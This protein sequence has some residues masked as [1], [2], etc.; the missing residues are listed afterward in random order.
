MKVYTQDDFI[1]AIIARAFCDELTPENELN[2]ATLGFFAFVKH[3]RTDEEKLSLVTAGAD[4]GWNSWEGSFRFISRAEVGLDNPRGDPSMTYP[5]AE[6][7]QLD[8]L[9]QNQSAATGVHVYRSNQIPQLAN[10]VLFGDNPSGEVF[11]IPADDLMSGG[12]DGIRRIL[13]NDG[14]EAKTLLELIRGKNSEQGRDQARRADLRFG[15]GPD[16][17]VFLLNKR[18]GIVRLLVR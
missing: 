15:S 12:Q 16:G 17:Q 2:D 14:G 13:F 10:L 6:Y 7:G 11:Y 9:L 18:D 1:V 4:L 8:P 3:Q 5:V